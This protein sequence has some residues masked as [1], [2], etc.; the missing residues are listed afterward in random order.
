M[1]SVEGNVATQVQVVSLVFA[2]STAVCVWDVLHNLRKEYQMF[3]R[4]SLSPAT[5]AYCASRIGALVYC[6]GVTLFS[7]STLPDC[8]AA[9]HGFESFYPVTSAGSAFLFYV[10]VL[11][12]YGGNRVVAVFF[13]FLW[14][15]VAATALLVPIG[16][17]GRALDGGRCLYFRALPN[18]PSTLPTGL[19]LLLFDTLVFFAISYRLVANHGLDA[20]SPT[21]ET[22]RWPLRRLKLLFSGANLPVFSKGLLNEGQEYYMITVIANIA[23]TTMSFWPGIGLYRALGTMPS[24][25]LT[26]IMACRVYRRTRLGL[27]GG[28][29]G[30]GLSLPTLNPLTTGTRSAPLPV[31]FAPPSMSNVTAELQLDPPLSKNRDVREPSESDLVLKSRSVLCV[32]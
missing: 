7:T 11:A 5:V 14:L 31:E 29:G 24:L 22:R 20:G 26:S 4:S 6:L 13:G 19:T 16:G 1:S 32:V 30:L 15:A 17:R 10:R 21:T 8:A 2:G 27:V 18:D 23:A 25:V 3:R 28:S 9:I 12:V